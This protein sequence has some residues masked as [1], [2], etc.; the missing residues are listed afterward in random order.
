MEAEL[1]IYKQDTGKLYELLKRT[2]IWLLFHSRDLELVE[3]SNIHT[4]DLK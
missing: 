1:F 3:S 4:L 2:L